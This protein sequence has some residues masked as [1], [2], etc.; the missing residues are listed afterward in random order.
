MFELIRAKKYHISAMYTDLSFNAFFLSLG[1]TSV[2]SSISY[3]CR[4][5]YNKEAVCH[6]YPLRPAISPVQLTLN[7][8]D[9]WKDDSSV[10]M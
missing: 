7:S 5:T 2:T 6:S 9:N 8:M 10:K 4:T 1:T 3:C